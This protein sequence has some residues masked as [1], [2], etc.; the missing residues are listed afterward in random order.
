MRKSFAHLVPG[1][2]SPS[3][4]N[5]IPT[6]GRGPAEYYTHCTVTA[7][8][9]T[10]QSTT[11]TAHCTHPLTLQRK[12]YISV[13]ALQSTYLVCTTLQSKDQSLHAGELKLLFLQCAFASR[14]CHF[15]VLTMHQ[16]MCVFTQCTALKCSAGQ[17][18][19]L[20]FS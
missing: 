13:T 8:C 15:V 3:L 9:C 7:K 1:E 12:V 11:V 18:I 10:L 6:C 4:N 2:L 17:C 5:S 19:L 14:H 16:V 20:K